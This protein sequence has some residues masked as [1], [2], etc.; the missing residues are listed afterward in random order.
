LELSLRR[1]FAV[2]IL[3]QFIL[4]LSFGLALGMAVTNP[5]QVTSGYY[6]NHLYVLLGLNVLATMAAI[7]HRDRLA[8]A[9][10]LVAAILSYLGSVLWLYEKRRAGIAL[11]A[12]VAAASLYGAWADT[13]WHRAAGTAA[14]VLTALDPPSGGLVLGMTMAAMFL[15]HWYLNS[16]TM[17]LGP[18]RRLVVLMAG[19]VCLRAVL[20]GAGVALGVADSPWPT[21]EQWLFL[22]L[23]WLS[24]IVGAL[25][26]AIM[27]WQTLKI[28]NT[29][30]ATGMLYVGVIAT[31]LG[32]LTSLL[33]TAQSAYP[34]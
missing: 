19:A 6:R 33:L 16:P 1:S 27:A 23:R 34:L 28:P 31:F 13:D 3:T 25:G 10:P 2:A 30:A 22:A 21:A 8:L 14:C 7:G 5:R 24:G 4:R 15:G 17:A 20:E 18:L 29:Q 26:V 12:L 9:P 32:E 11:L